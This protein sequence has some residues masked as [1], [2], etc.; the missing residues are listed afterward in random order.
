MAPSDELEYLKGLVAQLNEK[1][2]ALEDR[3]KHAVQGPRTPAQQLRTILVGPPGSGTCHPTPPISLRYAGLEALT[4]RVSPF[5]SLTQARVHKPRGYATSFASAISPR[6]TCFAS[7]S[8]KRP[9]SVGKP[10]KSLT[11]AHSLTTI[12]W[13]G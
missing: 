4:C 10:R 11:R 2:H 9:S 13:S 6:A 5:D 8:P 12:S 1:I 3:A 7:K